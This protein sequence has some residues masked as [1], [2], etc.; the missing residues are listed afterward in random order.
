MIKLVLSSFF[1]PKLQIISL[2]QLKLS[3]DKYSAEYLI[4]HSTLIALKERQQWKASVLYIIK[5]E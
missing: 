2:V 4:F 3:E 5:L 1:P